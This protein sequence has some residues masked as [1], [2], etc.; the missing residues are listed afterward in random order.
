VNSEQ[1]EKKVAGAVAAA[2]HVRVPPMKKAGKI[3]A[4]FV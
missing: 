2:C 4:F 1:A 3:P